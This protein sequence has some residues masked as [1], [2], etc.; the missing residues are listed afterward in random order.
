MCQS[1]LGNRAIWKSRCLVCGKFR[2]LIFVFFQKPECNQKSNKNFWGTINLKKW[3]L[4]TSIAHCCLKGIYPWKPDSYQLTWKHLLI[5]GDNH[6]NSQP[7]LDGSAPWGN[8][9]LSVFSSPPSHRVQKM[10]SPCPAT[11][12]GFSLGW[13]TQEIRQWKSCGP[14]NIWIWKSGV[15]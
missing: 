14:W 12:P 1:M 8:L 7:P 4:R 13:A 6:A 2:C 9:P 10:Q 5:H 15:S 11:F 3:I